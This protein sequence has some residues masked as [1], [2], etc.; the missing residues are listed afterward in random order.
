[1][2][3]W[4]DRRDFWERMAPFLFTEKH[5]ESVPEHVDCLIN[6]LGLKEGDAI[7]DMCCGPG[8]HSL[9]FARRGF[10]VTGVDVTANYLQEAR[11]Q[12]EREALHIEFIEEDMRSFQKVETFN[13][14]I[15]MYTS[16]GYF[17]DPRENFQ[18]LVNVCESLK[19]EGKLLIDL[20]GKEILARVFQ[21][22]G[23]E[24]Q[25]GAYLLQERKISRNWSW[26][27]NR[28]ILL[29]GSDH[30]EYEVCHWIYSAFELECMLQDAGFRTV[31]SYGDL[32]GSLYDHNARRLVCV[33]QR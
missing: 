31:V 22:R 12:A 33:G 32:A 8:R 2:T 13:A 3:H 6:L 24:E 7:L 18:V 5:W 29:E 30:H 11:V 27:E 1:M 21:E 17:E 4:H 9:E 19:D 25:D 16:F 26:I 15:M 28:W 14:A 20:M 10:K 23:W